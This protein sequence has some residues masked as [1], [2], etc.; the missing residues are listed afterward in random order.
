VQRLTL[1]NDARIVVVVVVARD[2]ARAVGART[3]RSCSTHRARIRDVATSPST[4]R[5]RGRRGTV[6]CGD[7]DVF[8]AAAAAA[9]VVDV[10]EAR[11][12]G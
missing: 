9:A 2:V 5:L 10:D 4:S 11:A 6:R 7:D 8:A 1:R 12:R 3:V